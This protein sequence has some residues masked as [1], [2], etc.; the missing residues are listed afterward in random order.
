MT[1]VNK[2][3]DAHRLKYRHQ[4]ICQDTKQQEEQFR[5]LLDQIT[6]KNKAIKIATNATSSK[7]FQQYF[8]PFCIGKV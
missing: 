6:I 4:K 7:F 5:K 8:C 2:P 1:Y 3:T